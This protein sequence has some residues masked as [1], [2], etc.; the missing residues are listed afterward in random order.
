M[1][2]ITFGGETIDATPAPKEPDEKEVIYLGDSLWDN[3]IAMQMYRHTAVSLW[4]RIQAL[5]H[6]IGDRPPSKSVEKAR[7]RIDDLKAQIRIQQY[8]FLL[9]EQSAEDRWKRLTLSQREEIEADEM[10]GVD[11]DA[12]SLYGCWSRRLGSNDRPP[13]GCVLD[14]QLWKFIFPQHAYAYTDRY[15]WLITDDVPDAATRRRKKT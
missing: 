11:V 12:D 8:Q 4:H 2:I 3:M 14:P 13:V 15:S 10:F 5:E 6:R 7:T 9:Q 1:A